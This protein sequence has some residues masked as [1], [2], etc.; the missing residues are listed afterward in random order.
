[1]NLDKRYICIFV[2]LYFRAFSI[3]LKFFSNKCDWYFQIN[4]LLQPW[5]SGFQDTDF[6]N[7]RAS[8]SL[9]CSEAW[10]VWGLCWHSQEFS[11]NCPRDWISITTFLTFLPPLT[12]NLGFWNLLNSFKRKESSIFLP[13]TYQW[14]SAKDDIPREQLTTFQD[15]FSCYGFKL[16]LIPSGWRPGTVLNTLNYIILHCTSLHYII[17]KNYPNVNCAE[18]G[19]PEHGSVPRF[20]RD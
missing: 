9:L 6:L 13:P 17:A 11:P 16:W 7:L 4:N 12:L 10:T 2:W 19:R 20:N 15:T 3:N 8:K 1:M 5:T 14:F 18:A